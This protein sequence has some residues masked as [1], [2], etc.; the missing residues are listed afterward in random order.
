MGDLIDR[1]KL[2]EALGVAKECS[3][4]QFISKIFFC[5]KS[6]DFV[7][8]CEQI[9]EAPAVEPDDWLEKNK[10]LILQAG[11]EGRE[12]EFR[13]DGRLFAIREKPQ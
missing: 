12:V 9:S 4:C 5:E 7:Y 2:M 1:D 10:D 11:M 3:D 8:A 13:M 6:Q